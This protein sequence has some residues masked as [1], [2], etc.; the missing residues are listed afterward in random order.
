MAVV[1]FQTP[2]RGGEDPDRKFAASDF[3]QGGNE[4]T[5]AAISPAMGDKR[6][7]GCRK[8]GIDAR[9]LRR[10]GTSAA[11]SPNFGS[12]VCPFFSGWR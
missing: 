8:G 1:S 12:A 2:L 5:D 10:G 9:R 11:A 7:G 4:E 6:R 3:S